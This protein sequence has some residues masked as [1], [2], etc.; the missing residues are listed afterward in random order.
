MTPESRARTLRVVARAL[1]LMVAVAALVLT[2]EVFTVLYPSGQARI[3]LA[4]AGLQALVAGYGV[5]F[6]AALAGV[7]VLAVVV[8]RARRRG[9]RRPVAARLLLLGAS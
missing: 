5:V 2:P 1:I 6:L 3:E 4:I 7:P 9:L 8:V